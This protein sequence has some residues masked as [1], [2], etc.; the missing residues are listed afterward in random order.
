[1]TCRIGPL[2][3]GCE[4]GSPAVRT[5]ASTHVAGLYPLSLTPPPHIGT[6]VRLFVQRVKLKR[7]KKDINL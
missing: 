4:P 1:M 3:V 5:V 6:L 2:N 7:D